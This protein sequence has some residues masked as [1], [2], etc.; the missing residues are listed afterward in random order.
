MTKISEGHPDF[1][2]FEKTIFETMCRIACEL[3]RQYLVWR[4]LGIMAMRDKKEYELVDIRGTTI[5]T[6]MGE[7]RYERRYYKKRSGGYVFLLDVAMGIFCGCGLTSE[8]LAEQVVSECTDKSF[9]KAAES[10]DSFTCQ[11]ISAMG[12]W[13]IFRKYSETVGAQVERMRELDASGSTGHL[14]NTSSRVLFDEY[15]DVWIPRQKETRRKRGGTAK[16]KAGKSDTKR[17]EK[18]GMKPMHVGTAYTGWEQSKDGAYSTVDKIAFAS[19]GAVPEFTSTFE[20]LLRQRFDMDGVVRRLTNGDGEGWIGTHADNNDSILQLDSYHRNDAIAKAVSDKGDRKLLHN[21]IREKDVEKMLCLILEFAMDAQDEP[22][23]D[24]LAKLYRYFRNNKDSLLTWQERGIELP[25]PPAGITYRG[26]GVQESNNCSLITLRMKHRRASW[27]E[28][29][30]DRMAQILCFKNTV[31]LDAM[32][33]ILPDPSP[34]KPQA[35]PLSAAKTPQHDGKGYGA[36]WLHAQMPFEQAFR[37]HGRKAIK[38][39]LR[40]KPLSELPFVLA[41]GIDKSCLHSTK[42]GERS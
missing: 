3:I 42:C 16:G 38:D 37:T 9:R 20:L 6:M 30:G 1:K 40:M 26:M 19:F 7:V 8:N 27:S 11:S 36:D 14:G 32:L 33:G 13:G 24:K 23:L 10:V 29:G 41:P 2:T 4:D 12:V 39:M 17:A 5:K 18:P 22:E 25:A 21:A 34:V 35:E 15:D 31:G 28:D